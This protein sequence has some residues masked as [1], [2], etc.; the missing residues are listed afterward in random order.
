[1]SGGVGTWRYMAPEEVRYEQ[2]DEKIDIFAF[3]LSLY[4]IFSGPQCLPEWF[5]TWWAGLFF[6]PFDPIDHA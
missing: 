4:F 3:S 6:D 5:M 2:Y 1:M